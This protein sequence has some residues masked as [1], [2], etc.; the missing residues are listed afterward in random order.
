MKPTYK[1]T[2]LY[3]PIKTLMEDQ[4]FT[5]RGEVKGCD[6]AAIRDGNLWIVEMKLSANLTLIYQALE[7]QTATDWVFIAIPRPRTAK[8]SFT[9]LKRLL[10]KLRLGLITVALDSPTQFAEII[11]FPEGNATKT[12]KKSATLRREIAGRLTDTTGGSTK[13]KINTAYRERCIRIACLLE[14]HG[15]QSA[16]NLKNI[17]GCENDTYSILRS[18]FYSWY[19]KVARGQFA[20]SNAGVAYLQENESEKLIVYYRM[21]ARDT[22]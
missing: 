2:D 19:E 15:P 17:Y 9:Q 6:I 16:A 18:N 3:N 13:A 12:T 11:L 4:G 10:K 7:R 14:S 5:V 21:R 1:E 8:G 22:L 20:L